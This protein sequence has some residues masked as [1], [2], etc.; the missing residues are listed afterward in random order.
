M[1]AEKFIQAAVTASVNLSSVI[2]P[3]FIMCSSFIRLLIIIQ[4]Y[5]NLSLLKIRGE[6]FLHNFLPVLACFSLYQ[7]IVHLKDRLLQLHAL[8]PLVGGNIEKILSGKQTFANSSHRFVQ[9]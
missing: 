1:P 5:Y 9:V 3:E 8:A 4:L 2:G 7:V 6:S